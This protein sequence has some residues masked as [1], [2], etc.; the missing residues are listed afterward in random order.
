[1]LCATDALAVDRGKIRIG[2]EDNSAPMSFVDVQGR[3]A[4]FTA[5]L[6]QAVGR[7]GGVEFEVTAKS[8]SYIMQEFEAGRLDALANVAITPERRATMDFSVGHASLHAIAIT[9][10]SAPPVRHLGDFKGK[11]M[12]LVPGSLSH[13]SAMEHGAWGA[14]CEF[15]KSRQETLQAVKDGQCDFALHLRP[16]SEPLT[17]ELGLRTSFVDDLVHRFHIAVHRGDTQTLERINEGLAGVLRDGTLDGIY[18]KWIGAIEPRPIRL[19]DLRPYVWPIVL[20]TALLLGILAW[21]QKIIAERKAHEREIARLNRVYATISRVNYALVQ[22]KDQAKLLTEICRIIVEVGG[23]NLAWVGWLDPVSRRLVPHAVAGDKHDYVPQVGIS[24]DAD[25]PGGQGPSGICFRTG[26]TYVCNDFF[27]DPA[28]HAWRERAHLSGI[29][30]SISLP[31]KLDGRTTGVLV[32]YAAEKDFFGPPEVAL[33]NETTV[34]VSFAL[35]VLAGEERRH[36]SEVMFSSILNSVPHAVFWKDRQSV[37]L[38]CNQVFARAAG[39]TDP[40]HI[41]GKSD[42]DL[43]WE[44]S[45]AEKYRADDQEV[46]Q[47][48]EAKLHIVEQIKLGE[49]GQRWLETSK[50]PLL[51]AAGQVYGLL[52]VFEDITE[53][54][55]AETALS[56]SEA[57]FRMLIRNLNAGVV[58]HDASARITYFNEMA[59]E[60]LGLSREQLL[61]KTSLDL[62]WNVI[63][64]DGSPFPGDTHPAVMALATRRPVR[65]VVMGVYNPVQRDRTWLLASA[66]PLP[67]EPLQVI[68]VF[69]DITRLRMTEA[70]LHLQGQAL[71]AT[72]NVVVITDTNGSIEWVNPAFTRSTGYTFEEAIGRNPRI[73]KSGLQ[74][75]A[76]YGELWRTITTGN[77]WSGEL[78]NSR[79]D[80]TQY[81]E[82][83]TITPVRDRTGTI[84]H[85]VAVK[86]DITQRKLLEKQ[87]FETQR[88]EGIGLLA[89]G[90]AHDLNNILSPILLSI[91]QMRATYPG[92]QP[93]LDLID[94]CARRG[95]DIVRQVLTFSRGMDGTRVPLRI[96]RLV[97]EMGH[98]MSETLPRNIE[99]NYDV[100]LAEDSVHVDPTQIHQVLL[101]LAVN[102]RDAMPNGGRLEMKLSRES[103]GADNP[104]LGAGAVPGD[105]VVIS[106]SDT[107]TGIPPEIL[108]RIFDPFF[109]TKPRGRG[110]GLGLS[111]VHGI[112]RG[113][114]GF[115][116]VQSKLGTG[117]TFQVY[118][119]AATVGE[120]AAQVQTEAPVVTGQGRLVLVADDE[121]AIRQVTR[122]VLEKNGFATLVVK[123]GNQAVEAFHTNQGRIKAVIL[124]RMMPVMGGEEAARRI[125]QSAPYLPIILSTG[126]VAEGSL[127]ESEN[128]LRKLGITAILHKPYDEA[129]LMKMLGSHV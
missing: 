125:R 34:D 90:I 110:T 30:S 62:S 91:E 77:S 84:T 42:F 61:G 5:E 92:E 3:P 70:R 87:L 124:D 65:D 113:H 45:Q 105:Y 119:P 112:V 108:A 99:L 35:D 86:Q 38:G 78:I 6:L 47:K 100:S 24:A 68:V 33:L 55:R 9:R 114:K 19:T 72:A 66:E 21:Q 93:S 67:G 12:A 26:R 128:E 31:I 40:G 116:Q 79:K 4:G 7:A 106:V 101:N 22:I 53:R 51:D 59:L 15:F 83:V 57:R 17:N 43:P 16:T 29:Q 10:P 73:L 23:F 41:V 98:L 69:H 129:A 20:V 48:R 56:E 118:L 81:S 64:D 82:E 80:G 44:K 111:T 18:A 126:L 122:Y 97:K 123:N 95:A 85:F 88:L 32:V 96:G 36:R 37:Y 28:T 103:L 50:M 107:G 2:V 115:I 121:E 74:P 89:S 11:K 117:T 14:E 109:T 52:G 27:S 102:A 13:L 58:L 1:M 46:M 120:V 49:G 8:W 104:Q 54:K 94:Q 71:E 60:L 75:E 76:T 127:L 25:T 39:L 63:H